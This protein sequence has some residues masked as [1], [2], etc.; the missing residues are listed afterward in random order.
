MGKVF[1]AGAMNSADDRRKAF[2]TAGIDL[3]K[4]ITVSC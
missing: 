2:E 4:P 1:N 3:A